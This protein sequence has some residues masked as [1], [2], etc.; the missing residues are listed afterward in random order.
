MEWKTTTLR[1]PIQVALFITLL[2]CLLS[3]TLSAQCYKP[4]SGRD[5]IVTEVQAGAPCVS[6]TAISNPENVK[7]ANDD[8]YAS[9]AA[10]QV[11]N[12]AGL[13]VRDTL[14][15]F[16][17]GWHA[18]FAVSFEGTTLSA[19]LLSN[20]SLATYNN[21]T[22]QET[23]TN[24]TGLNITLL[25]NN[26]G[27]LYLNFPTIQAFDEVRLTFTNVVGITDSFRIYF[28]M[29]FDPQCGLS[30]N[31]SFC[32][33]QI[34]GPSAELTYN[35]GLANAL[36]S[37]ADESNIT[38]GNKNSFATL[39]LP[40]ATSLLAT[41]PYV[42]VMEKELV[43]PAGHRAGFI[44]GYNSSLLT[45]NVLNAISVQTYLHG[46]LRETAQFNNGTGLVRVRALSTGDTNQKELSF[47]T[48]QSF[49]EVRLV[50]AQ[51]ATVNVGSIRIYYA[52]ESDS[53][54]D[55]ATKLLATQAPPDVG[56][57]NNSKTG[58]FGVLC[59]GQSLTGAGNVVNGSTTDFATFVPAILSVGCGA[60]ISV[61]NS[62]PNYPSGT[63]AGFV[64]S[65]HGGLID[66][67]LLDAIT[68][69]VYK[70]GGNTPV[71]SSSGAALLA[72]GVLN[73]DD[74]LTT[75]GFKPNT[76][77]DEIQIVF[78]S[79]LISASLAGSYRIYY[80]QV[81][82]DSDS[83]TVPDPIDIC[84]GNDAIDT[85]GDG[86][87]D[88]CDDCSLIN[89]KSV[90]LD[91]DGDGIKNSC[92]ADSDD[93]G[94]ADAVE[95]RGTDGN[96]TN[97]DAD[98]DGIANYL[99]LD[100]DDDGIADLDESGISPV[101]VASL[102]ANGNKVIDPNI[103]RGNNG[104]ANA[105]ETTDTTT[106]GNN[107]LLADKDGDGVPDFVDLDSD[108]DG[109]NDVTEGYNGLF[110]D[111]N[112]D[113][114]VDGADDDEDGIRN[115]ADGDP[116]LGSN[117]VGTPTDTDGDGVP[118]FRD[119]DSDN[120]L[121]SDLV[122]NGIP[123][124]TDNDQ[125][126][127]ADGSDTDGDGI[128]DALDGNNGEFGDANQNLPVN[129]D[130]D[131]VPD[132]LDPDSNNDGTNDIADNGNG[133]QDLDSDGE[134][135]NPSD[136]DG[137]GIPNNNG[138]DHD[139][140][141]FGGLAK[142]TMLN[143][144]VL[145]QGALTSS[146]DTLMQDNLRQQGLI[147]F[148]QPY[149]ASLNPRFSQY[150]GGGNEATTSTFLNANANTQNAI[151]DWVMIEF[152][153]SYA[154]ASVSKTLNVFVQ[155]DGDI[156]GA[157]G[158]VIGAMLDTGNYYLSIKHRNHLGVMTS[159][160]SVVSGSATNVDFRN[161]ATPVYGTNGMKILTSG[162]R[163]LFG[164]DVNM[165]GN[166]YYTAPG[167]DRDALLSILS[168]NQFGYLSTYNSGDINLDGQ[169]YMTAPG[170]DRDWLLSEPLNGDE[171]NFITEQIPQ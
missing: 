19:S 54:A 11:V 76:A 123:G 131:T 2:L 152:R 134:V 8:N 130:S 158:N 108:N 136:P 171:F 169:T 63:F 27:K 43:H 116:L 29:A 40:A 1:K 127:V 10:V 58:T 98:R 132:Y 22:L 89:G 165:N 147:P 72:L 75:I 142:A 61:Q 5:V 87:P 164:G 121:I 83:D 125:N 128:V 31:N 57:L 17:A 149:S 99:D 161:S 144:K 66:A 111:A 150:G 14:R 15:A 26:S 18:G 170:N 148:T 33:D 138:S 80:A 163:A 160:A 135:D 140:N 137:D 143:V 124:F 52:F 119:L 48:S 118:N 79:G 110:A 129:T 107:Y 133:W 85:D 36:V 126:G 113:G 159:T 78:N 25:G 101:T 97:D 32:Y 82:K 12:G 38:D 81:I 9:L 16:A 56:S 162:K 51:T 69:N 104:F 157:D 73:D 50:V 100:S 167:N 34:A 91:T 84:A 109:I 156:V 94:I 115:I 60:Q 49:N 166:V 64:I 93:D 154:P 21:G 90:Y 24:L 106:T 23:K 45:A 67:G 70:D 92:D 122:E 13:S 151:V 4:I 120:D 153:K 155:R 146:S 47:V 35:G 77:F 74:S 59:I 3:F 88:D 112:G 145:L 105:V 62:G 28:A 6:C 41:P 46:Q 42:G 44:I 37:L 30:D 55:V 53:C 7:D 71:A 168:G 114:M 96:P 139:P 68:I 39:S 141:D 102:D 86:V 95:D 117:N 20:L 103:A 65:R